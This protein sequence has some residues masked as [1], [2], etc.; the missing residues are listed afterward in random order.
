[1]FNDSLRKHAVRAMDRL[2]AHPITAMFK[3][4]VLKGEEPENYFQ[5][6]TNPQDLNTIRK[7]LEE[8]KYETIQSWVDDVETV[9]TNC[10]SYYSLSSSRSNDRRYFIAVTTEGRKIFAKEKSLFDRLSIGNWCRSVYE[11]RTEVTDFMTQPPGKVKQFTP[12]L[13]TARTM[14]QAAPFA[15]DRDL[16]NFIVAGSMLTADEDHREMIKI[17]CEQNPELDNGNPE[18]FIDVT[19]LNPPTIQALKDFMKAALERQ[20]KKYPE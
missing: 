4:P 12:T 10:D 3:A 18:L 19:R 11:L 8:G 7:R 9:W 13:G 16:Q 14:K 5:I 6:V 15:N 1:M 20:G 2:M 17:L